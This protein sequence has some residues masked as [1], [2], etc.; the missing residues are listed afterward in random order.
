MRIGKSILRACIGGALLLAGRTAASELD[1]A[2]LYLNTGD[3]EKA[4]GHAE[5]AY[6]ADPGNPAVKLIYAQT[7]T[8][9]SDAKK[10]Y[11]E[12]AADP[13]APDSLRAAAC[14]RLAGAYRLAGDS[15][16]ASDMEKRAMAALSPSASALAPKDTERTAPANTARPAAPSAEKPE[17]RVDTVFALQVGSYADYANAKSRQE[18]LMKLFDH[19]RMQDAMVDGRTVYRVRIGSFT[20]REEAQAYGRR[21]MKNRG[22]GFSIVRE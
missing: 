11:E 22:I 13:G 1:S 18:Q 15:A 17:A 7:L 12:L 8:D 19:V 2:R 16:R 20:T 6:L 4:R 9:G 21:N 5:S 3:M 14:G 10:L